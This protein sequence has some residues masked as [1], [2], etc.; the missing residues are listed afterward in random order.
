[1]CYP[2]FETNQ[3]RLVIAYIS[4]Q[5]HPNVGEYTIQWY[6]WWCVM[7]NQAKVGLADW[8]WL[9]Q[10][11]TSSMF[12]IRDNQPHS[13]GMCQTPTDLKKSLEWSKRKIV[14]HL[15]T[16]SLIS[17][18]SSRCFQQMIPTIFLRTRNECQRDVFQDVVVRNTFL[19][20]SW[21]LPMWCCLSC[22]LYERPKWVT[23]ER[24][25]SMGKSIGKWWFNVGFMGFYGGLMGFNGIY[26]LV[27]QHS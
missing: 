27:N 23:W 26:S 6:V 17:G 22:K 24:P 20:E 19:E 11:L 7:M 2:P 13:S 10:Q 1:M 18:N 3:D 9:K 15:S 8:L 12:Q 14:H 4:R 16:V 21:E 25:I 5:Q